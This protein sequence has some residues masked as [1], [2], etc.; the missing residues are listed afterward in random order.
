MRKGTL[1]ITK[2]N[3]MMSPFSFLMLKYKNCSLHIKLFASYFLLIFIPI[4]VLTLFFSS[5]S[6]EII[7]NQSLEITQ[8][9]LK[10]TENEAEYEFSKLST[11]SSQISQSA[12]IHK[13]LDKQGTGIEFGEEYDDMNA[14]YKMIASMCSIQNIYQIRLFID[15]SFW[16]SRSNYITFPMSSIQEESWYKLLVNEFKSQTALPPHDFRAPL[17]EPIQVLS[18]ATLIRSTKDINTILGVALVDIPKSELLSILHRNNYAKQSATYLVDENLNIICG[19][20]TS[21]HLPDEE[22]HRLLEMTANKLS[23]SSGVYAAG[24]AVAGLSAP[25]YGDWRIFTVASFDDLL[26][27]SN[28]LRNQLIILTVIVSVIVFIMAYLYSRYSVK[29]IKVLAEQVQK[30]ESGDLSVS[31]I[32]DSEDEIGELQNSFNFMVRRINLLV[33]EQYNLGKNLKDMELRALQAQINPHF[34]Y[35]T[36]DI[37]SWKAKANGD[38]DAVDVVL[39][40][41]RFYRLSLSNGCDFVPLRDEAEH[42][43][44]FVELTNLCRSR[45]VELITEIAPE[46]EDYPI[47]KLILQPIVENSLFHGL[48]DLKGRSGVVRLSACLQ[49]DYVQICITDNGLGM[50]K[51]KL[52]EILTEKETPAVNSKHGGYGIENIIE[53]LKLYYDDRYSFQIESSILNGTAVTIRIPYT[54]NTAPRISADNSNNKN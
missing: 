45:S 8:L 33:N 46:I 37:I 13:V 54:Q 11:I 43:R 2:H 52:A 14:L 29:R 47:M 31:C 40:L 22:V 51:S 20:D 5:R 1:C 19:E 21:L 15:D 53:R 24:S 10:Q 12:D 3:D 16:H 6:A 23:S 25:V 7:T 49:G 38:D 35:N 36:L 41:A 50:E 18:V 28:D 9:Y 30:V 4:I 42:V 39:K 26:T 27:S 48:Y 17:S 44:L 32:V 34:L